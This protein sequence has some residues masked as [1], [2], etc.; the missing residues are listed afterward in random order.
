MKVVLDTNV[1]LSGIFFGG[2]PGRILEE[3]QNGR[4]EVLVSRAIL[5]EY[6]VASEKVARR[7]SGDDALPI[8]SHL[9]TRWRLV[10][11]VPLREPVCRDP[12]DDK[13]LACARAA[14]ADVIVSGD[15]DLLALG[16]WEGIAILSPRQFADAHL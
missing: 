16:R 5:D 13:F 8:L 14:A 9:A 12:S 15:S 3:W 11:A 2:T 6:V 10:H 1:L 7:Y 4:F